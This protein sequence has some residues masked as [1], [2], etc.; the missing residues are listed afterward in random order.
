MYCA[1]GWQR[2]PNRKKHRQRCPFTLLTSNILENASKKWTY[3]M[4]HE[5]IYMHRL[6]RKLKKK[7]LMHAYASA[8]ARAHTHTY[9]QAGKEVWFVDTC[10]RTYTC[11]H[12]CIHSHTCTY[13]HTNIHAYIHTYTCTQ[14]GKEAWLGDEEDED[15]VVHI[16]IHT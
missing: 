4:I 14:T 5:D 10:T 13:V 12:A 8:R 6:A 7:P 2:S 3:T 1:P 11:I 15:T 9:A 16:H